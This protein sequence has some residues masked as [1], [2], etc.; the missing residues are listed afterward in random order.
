MSHS[1]RRSRVEI[2]LY[3][4]CLLF[5]LIWP[6]SLGWVELWVAQSD[7]AQLCG[8]LPWSL[9]NAIHELHPSNARRP[10]VGRAR[11]FAQMHGYVQALTK[12]LQLKATCPSLFNRGRQPQLCIQLGVSLWSVFV[13]SVLIEWILALLRAVCPFPSLQLCNCRACWGELVSAVWVGGS[14]SLQSLLL[15]ALLLVFPCQPALQGAV[16]FC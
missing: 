10:S 2:A 5:P 16:S 9:E 15:F 6:C 4:P 7:F 11:A 8:N 14:S 12:S 3:L 1:K 13:S